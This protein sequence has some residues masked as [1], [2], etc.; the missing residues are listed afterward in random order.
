MYKRFHLKTLLTFFCCASLMLIGCSAK[1]AVSTS[2]DPSNAQFDKLTRKMFIDYVE[3]DTLTINYTLKNPSVYGIDPGEVT[4]GDIPVTKED[5]EDCKEDTKNYLNTLRTMTDLNTEQALTYDV[6]KYYLELD[7]EGY[8]YV[9][10]TTNFAPMLGIQSQ[11]PTTMAEYPFDDVQDVEDYLELLNCVENYFV[12]LID[13][14]N[15]KAANGYGMCVSAL[16]QSIEECKAFCDSG[17]NNLLLEVFPS[18][19]DALNLTESEKEAYIKANEEAIVNH[20]IPAYRQV[21]DALSSQIDTAPSEGT[22]ASYTRGTDYYEYLLKASVGTDKNAKELIALTEEN[23][24]ACFMGL[25][26][27]LMN[28]ENIFDE[29]GRQTFLL[30]DPKEI[31]EHFKN[32]LTKEQFPQAP[33]ADYTLKNVHTSMKDIL[34]P[35]M[36]FI[37]RIDD[38]SNNQ[39][40]MNLDNT[41]SSNE[42]MPTLAHE[43]YPG[44]MYQITYYY[45]TQPNPIRTVYECDGYME[46]WASYAES[47]AYDYCGFSE[48]VADFNRIFNST[49]TL[50]LYCRLDL[51]VHYENWS[52]QEMAN[53]VSAYLNLPDETMVDLYD[54]ILYNPTNYLIYGIGME[55]ICELRDQMKE[56]LGND[57]NLQDFHRQLLDIGPAPFPIIEKYMPDAANS[58]ESPEENNI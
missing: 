20:L 29:A 33:E 37:P 23:I 50:N 12:Q 34:S 53:Y 4:W 47:L 2:S 58:L 42:L 3:N 54:A 17:E 18:R 22:L 8:E 1:E 10:F 41:N 7:L 55:E 44:H 11:L 13:F 27:L 36:Y 46:G 32:T 25:S 31:I 26:L 45:N 30:D 49:L 14:E 6:L 21:I 24:D 40:Y 19:L 43:G 9:Y 16:N 52:L 38:I 35:A 51:G 57:F 5:F 56:N 28:N 15:E 39:I 48:D